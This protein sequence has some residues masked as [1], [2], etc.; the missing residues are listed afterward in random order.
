[1]ATPK[2]Q[3]LLLTLLD[4]PRPPDECNVF[5]ASKTHRRFSEVYLNVSSLGLK[6]WFSTFLM[7]HPL[8]TV[9]PVVVTPNY[10]LF[11]CCYFIIIV[12]LLL[13]CYYHNVNIYVFLWP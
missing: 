8:N 3:L 11:F 6:R 1:M 7:W 12:L 5:T 13:R 10:K 9:P 2:W 4:P